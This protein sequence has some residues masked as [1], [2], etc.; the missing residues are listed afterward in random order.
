MNRTERVRVGQHKCPDVGVAKE[1]GEED[2][3]F[4]LRVGCL[5][6]ECTEHL[7]ERFV[8]CWIK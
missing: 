1:L 8:L 2:K 3:Y 6:F 4:F 7:V 5:W